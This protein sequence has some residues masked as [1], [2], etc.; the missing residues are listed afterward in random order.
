MKYSVVWF[1]V[2]LFSMV[3]G[4]SSKQPVTSGIQE[5]PQ[6]APIWGDGAEAKQ[7]Y[8]D[9]ARVS[10]QLPDA[11]G[12]VFYV[13]TL[14]QGSFVEDPAI[15]QGRIGFSILDRNGKTIPVMKYKGSY[16]IKGIKGQRYTIAFENQSNRGYE[17]L[18]TADGID[19]ITGQDGNYRNAGYILF[20][21]NSMT[22]KGFRQTQK[23]F[24]PFTFNEKLSP[25]L[26]GSNQGS[27][28]N[29][30]VIGFAIFEVKTPKATQDLKP[31]AFPAQTNK[32]R[33]DR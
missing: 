2:V 30:G 5:L 14:P 28:A 7:E 20:P 18:V 31:K 10:E 25:Y 19:T 22:I 24:K 33:L 29:I 9:V 17:V 26:K 1:F 6:T 16:Y 13:A 4:C 11:L 15:A 23:E 3:S 21:G 27:D 12:E 32:F 8:I